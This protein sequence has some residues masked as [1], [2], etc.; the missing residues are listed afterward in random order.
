MLQRK[1]KVKGKVFSIPVEQIEAS[2]FQARTQFDEQEIARLA[3]SIM[4][5]GLLQPVSVR[6]VGDKYQLIAG[7][8]RLRA[9]KMAQLKEVPAILCEYKDQQ[10]AALGLLENIQRQNLNP[11]EQANGIRE[12]IRLWGCT[13]EEAA[14]RLGMAQPTLNNK[15]R[16]LTLTE[17]QQAFCLQHNLSER[18]ARAVL[19][20]EQPELRTKVLEQFARQGMNARQADAYVEKMVGQGARKKSIP[21]IKDVR[22]FV[23]TINKAVRLMVEAG[24][25]ASTQRKDGEGYVE[26]IVHIPVAETAAARK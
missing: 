9:C 23:N 14:K 15:L 18:H 2:P 7:E 6:K 8:R 4:Q 13:Q 3:L 12:V 22:I 17:E 10:T 16:L 25:P 19:R 20:I 11:F 21:M 24:V 5:N 26:Y 1:P